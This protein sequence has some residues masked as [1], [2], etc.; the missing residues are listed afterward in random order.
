M[1]YYRLYQWSGLQKK[2]SKGEKIIKLST[3]ERNVDGGGEIC[4]VI[5]NA[6]TKEPLSQKKYFHKSTIPL[7]YYLKCNNQIYFLPLKYICR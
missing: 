1:E 4:S 6:D 2:L 5:T 7:S 3:E